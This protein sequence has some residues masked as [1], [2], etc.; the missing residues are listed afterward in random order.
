MRFT[1]LP[2]DIA[3]KL[4][5]DLLEQLESKTVTLTDVSFDSNTDVADVTTFHGFQREF[6][7]LKTNHSLTVKWKSYPNEKP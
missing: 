2:H 4:L 1:G 5:G 6:I 3:I 7:E